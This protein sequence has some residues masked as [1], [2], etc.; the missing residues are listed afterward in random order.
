MVFPDLIGVVSPR[1]F[2]AIV[3]I[4]FGAYAFV[5]LS[6]LSDDPERWLSHLPAVLVS[7]LA[8]GMGLMLAASSALSNQV[9]AFLWGIMGVLAGGAVGFIAGFVG[10]MELTPEDNLGPM[11]GFLTLVIARLPPLEPRPKAYC[12]TI[13]SRPSRATSALKAATNRVRRGS[14]RELIPDQIRS[15]SAFR[16]KAPAVGAPSAPPAP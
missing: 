16:S 1:L 15:R 11:L 12:T 2:A 7:G 5:R 13:P 6:V 3:G 14:R 4:L 10:P 8:A 9:D